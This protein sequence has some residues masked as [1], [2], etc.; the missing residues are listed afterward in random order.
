MTPDLRDEID[1]TADI[2]NYMI[3]KGDHWTGFT[4]QQ[5]SVV[6]VQPMVLVR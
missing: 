5:L 3:L 1:Y 2:V 6:R 4:G